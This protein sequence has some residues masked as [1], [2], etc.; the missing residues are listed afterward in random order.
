MTRLDTVFKSRNDLVLGEDMVRLYLLA[1]SHDS[2]RFT[3]H[4]VIASRL[5][6]GEWTKK[7]RAEIERITIER[8]K[9]FSQEKGKVES[10]IDVLH[11]LE[12][13]EKAQFTDTKRQVNVNIDLPFQNFLLLQ[14]TRP[15]ETRY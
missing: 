5:R 6:Q 11:C 2:R 10:M 12:L 4:I 13:L 3:F 7:R 15:A 1:D 9:G 14:R 8:L